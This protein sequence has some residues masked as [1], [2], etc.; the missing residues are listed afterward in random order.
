MKKETIISEIYRIQE[1]MG[2]STKR[3][4]LEQAWVDDLL[5]ALGKVGKTFDDEFEALLSNVKNVNLTNSIRAE[6]LDKLIR[7][8]KKLGDEDLIKIFD[9]I[10]TSEDGPLFQS[11]KNSVSS[12]DTI[13]LIS[14]IAREENSTAKSVYDALDLNNFSPNTGDEI[15]DIWYVNRLKS[16]LQKVF[17]KE[18]IAAKP[19]PQQTKPDIQDEVTPVPGPAT[20]EKALYDWTNWKE[21]SLKIDEESL[22][23]LANNTDRAWFEKNIVDNL[24]L[25]EDRLMRI[26]RLF[27]AAT[28]TTNAAI[29]NQIVDQLV[30]DF[31]FLFKRSAA[32]Y[33]NMY[34]WVRNVRNELAN[35]RATSKQANLLSRVL[36]DLETK[37]NVYQTFGAFSPVSKR[38]ESFYG[39]LKT[40]LQTIRQSGAV[41]F[42]KDLYRRV[43]NGFKSLRGKETRPSNLTI[44]GTSPKAEELK[45][46]WQSNPATN[47]LI[48]GSRRGLPSLKNPYYQEIIK[49]YN[50]QTAWGVYLTETF[51]V[52]YLKWQLLE[53]V[54][55]TLRNS[56]SWAIRE[57]DVETCLIAR[58]EQISQ[59]PNTETSELPFPEECPKDVFFKWALDYASSGF[60]NTEKF[61]KEFIENLVTDGWG[62]KV[63][64]FNLIPGFWDNIF[65]AIRTGLKTWDDPVT[66]SNLDET[67]GAKIEEAKNKQAELEAKMKKAADT[68]MDKV[69]NFDPNL[70]RLIPEDLLRL[71]PEGSHQYLKRSGTNRFKLDFSSFGDN[72]NYVI[73]KENEKWVILDPRLNQKIPVSGP[74]GFYT[75]MPEQK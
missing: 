47:W 56:M 10:L 26:Q 71:I 41:D 4:L 72:Q 64:Y 60:E 12:D 36:S 7:K 25:T 37:S 6:N 18:K 23:A 48:T 70:T 51:L 74:Q 24:T 67:L 68:T 45:D 21:D 65:T 19:K 75:D 2:V 38:I 8:A 16:E 3:I 30:D 31:E 73:T 59:N 53:A 20:P 35:N 54:L 46:Y 61:R 55:E 62:D 11:I 42:V 13:D 66:W 57:G 39:V 52:N 1:V 28:S 63:N 14:R 5:V 22:V 27:K 32:D 9:D 17:N 44:K 49:K 40:T 58:E 33:N 43:S 15:I 29:R 34:T 69:D 50:Y